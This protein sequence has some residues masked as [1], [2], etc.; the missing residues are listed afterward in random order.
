MK[1]KQE[2][3][4]RTFRRPSPIFMTIAYELG[5]TNRN[6]K[7][8]EGKSKQTLITTVRNHHRT[9]ASPPAPSFLITQ[10]LLRTT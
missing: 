1:I 4:D 6:R 3:A 7:Y 5:F 8:F 10:Y 9:E 2:E